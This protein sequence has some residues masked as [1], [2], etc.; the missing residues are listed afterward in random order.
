[1]PLTSAF[2]YSHKLMHHPW[3]YKRIHKKHHEFIAPVAMAAVY[4][5]PL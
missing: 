1:M 2:F 3:I 5:H 4:A